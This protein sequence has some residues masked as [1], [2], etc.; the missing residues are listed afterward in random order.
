M[1]VHSAEQ[2]AREGLALD[3]HTFCEAFQRTVAYH[4]DSQ[5]LRTLGGEEV[6]TWAAYGDRVR[7]IAAGLAGD[8]RA[9]RATR[10]G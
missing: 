6:I 2:A 4:G 8:R 9:R 7:A 5:A 1:E 3:A 10:S